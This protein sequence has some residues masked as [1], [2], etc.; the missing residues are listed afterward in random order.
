MALTSG[1]VVVKKADTA[2]AAR[3]LA[4]EQQINRPD[5]SAPA[6]EENAPGQQA[7]APAEQPQAAPAEADQNRRL[8][9]RTPRP[10][11]R[12]TTHR[13]WRRCRITAT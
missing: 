6:P 7:A 9:T 4:Y 11:R 2:P 5:T 3:P 10:A 13:K 1:P 12:T 8:R